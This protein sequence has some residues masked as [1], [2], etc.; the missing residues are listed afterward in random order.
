[1]ATE[2]GRSATKVAP[3][4]DVHNYIAQY[5]GRTRIERLL[6]IGTDEA[7]QA[8]VEEAKQGK[9]VG[10]YQAAVSALRVSPD[11]AWIDGT[12]KLVK[13]E[14]DRLELELKGYKNNLIKES[15]RVRSTPTLRSACYLC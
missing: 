2:N 3:T 6:L 14:T 12:N 8:A 13:A 11:I 9:D 10:L 5:K 1:M 4:F 15:I 7:R